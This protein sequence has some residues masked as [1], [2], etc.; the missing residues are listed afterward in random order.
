VPAFILFWLAAPIS[1][2]L[3]KSPKFIE[4][5]PD[6]VSWVVAYTR[7]FPWYGT[8]VKSL[9]ETHPDFGVARAPVE[10]HLY[11]DGRAQFCATATVEN[12]N[13]VAK[14]FILNSLERMRRE[15]QQ[16]IHNMFI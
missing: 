12:S 3:V 7:F 13:T 8:V 11:V 1:D 10:D 14:V 5:Q 16:R 2:Q 15:K 4:P 6:P 9:R